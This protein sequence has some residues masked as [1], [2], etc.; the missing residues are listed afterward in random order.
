MTGQQA[1]LKL[2]S[3][4]LVEKEE[5]AAAAVLAKQ[6]EEFDAFQ[7]IFDQN[8]ERYNALDAK[9]DAG[10]LSA[11]EETEFNNMQATYLED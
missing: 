7:A 8:V 9:A 11:E 6:R 1:R 2:A 3:N 10:N 4:V 5:I